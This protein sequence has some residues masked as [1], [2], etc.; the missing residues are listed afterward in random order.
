MHGMTETGKD[1][2]SNYLPSSRQSADPAKD[3]AMRPEPDM[4]VWI[5]GAGRFG[6]RA[7][8]KLK[9]RVNAL[10]IVIDSNPRTCEDACVLSENIVCRDG[11]DFLSER[12]KRMSGPKWVIPAVPVHLAYD[13]M[14]RQLEGPKIIRSMPIPA[15]AAEQLPNPMWGRKGELYLSNADFMCPANCTEPDRICSYTGKP[16]PR[17]LFQTLR[18]FRYENFRSIVIRSR[19]LAPG[20]GGYTPHDLYGVLDAVVSAD[21]PVLMSTACKCHGVLNAFTVESAL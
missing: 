1:L 2:V 13:W 6:L 9:K 20:V 8:C 19:Q 18:D 11:V 10:Y 5:I 7:F 21:G 14:R 4:D 3:A 12:L 17:L 16:R 15:A